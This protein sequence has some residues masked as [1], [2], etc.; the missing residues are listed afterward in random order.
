[1]LNRALGLSPELNKRRIQCLIHV[2][3][4]FKPW[5]PTP[6]TSQLC[7]TW[8]FCLLFYFLFLALFI[9]SLTT[10]PVPVPPHR[11]LKGQG[12]S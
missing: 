1:M 6:T 2:R 10:A 5:T 8:H 3:L 4:S 11:I 9:F 7:G 12:L